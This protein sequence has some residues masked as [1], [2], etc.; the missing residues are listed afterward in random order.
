MQPHVGL[1]AHLGDA[2]EIVDHSCVGRSRG[3]DDR[4]HAVAIL[5]R[6]TVDGLAQRRAP[7]PTLFVGGHEHDIGIDRPGRRGHA[8]VRALA[9]QHQ[10]SRSIMRAIGSVTPAEPGGDQRAEVARRAAGDEHS[11]GR[12]GHADQVGDVAQR[13]VLGVDGAAALEPRPGVDARGPDHEIEQDRRLGRRRR[14]ERQEPRMVDRDARRTEHVG[15]DS[16]RLEPADPFGGHGLADHR[17]QLGGRSG[18]VERRRVHPHALDGVSHDGLRQDLGRRIVTMHG[19]TLRS[20]SSLPSLR[21][22]ASRL[23]TP[24]SA[25]AMSTLPM[26]TSTGRSSSTRTI[27]IAPGTEMT[28]LARRCRLVGPR[29]DLH[30]GARGERGDTD[31]AARRT[32]VAEAG[33]VRLVERRERVHVGQEAQRLGD[34]GERRADAGELGTQVLD[35]LG[36]LRGNAT[37]DERSVLHPQLAADDDPIASTTT[38]VYGPRGLLMMRIVRAS[39]SSDTQLVH[40]CRMSMSR[41]HFLAGAGALSWWLL[42]A[43]IPP[44]RFYGRAGSGY[45][46]DSRLPSDT[47]QDTF[48]PGKIRLP[49]SLADQGQPVGG[50]GRRTRGRQ[51]QG[52]RLQR[53]ADRHGHCADPR[54]RPRDPVLGVQRGDRS[55][56]DLHAAPRWRRR[57]RG[58]VP[59]HRNRPVTVPYIGSLLPPFDTPTVDDHRGVEPYCSLTPAPCP[60]HDITLTE[61]LATGKPVVYMV[62]TPAH[63]QTG[64]CAPALEFLVKSHERLGDA[65][66]MVHA[67]VYAD[68]AATTVAPAVAALGLEYEP[69]LYL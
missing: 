66:A 51:R 53:Q 48:V 67:D 31:R 2:G 55:A 10:A 33:D 56:G 17:P 8:G 44:V 42:A 50:V 60:L 18:L 40:S 64:T 54:D 5:G 16:Q 49:I 32:V 1:G 11:A 69:V 45:D 3:R 23:R 14:H 20:S 58:G 57:V 4:E 28:L 9:G 47:R 24:P 19:H 52:A 38:G 27:A 59:G 36:G 65:V 37:A 35:G 34:V 7:H 68:N 25:A 22:S 21:T 29:L 46:R 13:L 62:G 6:E 30:R 41:R 12:V 63:C 15:E 43:T 39:P 26:Q 61:A